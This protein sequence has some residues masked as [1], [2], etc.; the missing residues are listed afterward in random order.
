MA[1]AVHM[2]AI[3]LPHVVHGGGVG[4]FTSSTELHVLHLKSYSGITR[5]H[6]SPLVR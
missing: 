6:L 1:G 4:S 2:R 3:V 5:T